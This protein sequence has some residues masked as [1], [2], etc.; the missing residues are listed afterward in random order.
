MIKLT[1]EQE[2]A[3]GQFR[4][5]RKG[6]SSPLTI[7]AENLLDPTQTGAYLE[8][9]KNQLGAPDNKTAASILIK[10][11]AFLPVIY[12]YCMTSWNV[13]LDIRHENITIVSQER[14]GLWLPG[15]H[16]V[17]LQGQGAGMDRDQWREDAVRTLFKGH[18]FPLINRI[19]SEGKVS[20][21]IL[22]ENIAIYLFWLYEKIL[23]LE[24][25]SERA[26][27]DYRF[28]LEEAPGNLFG[29]ENTNPLKKF[30]SRKILSE[31]TGEMV[32]PRKTCCYSY[33]TSSGKRCGTCPH[34]C[35]S[36]RR[37]PDE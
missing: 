2:E 26:A 20:R 27:E 34:S 37:I 23:P 25:H 12:L 15:F 36:K 5:A 29:C 7:K 24:M 10:R 31:N 17:R 30:D 33:L 28:I 32:R 21:L 9:V 6:K 14:D 22:W 18:I 19:A 8:A 1:G 35:S 11:Y 3:L 4:L 13:K 16:F